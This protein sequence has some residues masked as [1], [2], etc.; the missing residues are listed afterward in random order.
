MDRDK[1]YLWKIQGAWTLALLAPNGAIFRDHD[2]EIVL[3][4]FRARNPKVPER[5]VLYELGQVM[6]EGREIG[7]IISYA[8]R[9]I[10]RFVYSRPIE[11]A[12]ACYI[13][14]GFYWDYPS[15]F[16]IK[17]KETTSEEKAVITLAYLT[18][19]PKHY[20][21]VDSNADGP[22]LENW[23]CE[24]GITRLAVNR[25]PAFKS[26]IPPEFQE[27]KSEIQEETK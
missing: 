1:L 27:E 23:L 3:S 4:A 10:T 9:S 20:V 19:T 17:Y 21:L 7:S 26:T 22:M 25:G 14:H 18:G 24:K 2:S 13:E 11:Q 15:S 16:T 12:I 8:L 6:I 5:V